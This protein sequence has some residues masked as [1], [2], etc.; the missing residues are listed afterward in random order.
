MIFVP[1]F[2]IAKGHFDSNG[3]KPEN[4]WKH[5]SIFATCV[6]HHSIILPQPTFEKK[7]TR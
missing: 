7:A 3:V 5:C 6:L 2:S 1:F 4:F